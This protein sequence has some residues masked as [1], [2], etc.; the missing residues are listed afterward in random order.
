MTVLVDSA[1]VFYQA[2]WETDI[3]LEGLWLFTDMLGLSSYALRSCYT[4]YTSL[5]ELWLHYQLQ[6]GSFPK[7]ASEIHDNLINYQSELN[8]QG[9]T[10]FIG[11]YT[12]R[13]QDF[14]FGLSRALYLTI[15]QTH[16]KSYVP[17]SLKHM[18]SEPLRA[19]KL[20]QADTMRL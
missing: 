7:A 13:Y 10:S 14:T 1:S 18:L 11:L 5:D 6:I 3:I 20:R 15:L 2:G 19:E 16:F 4:S 12:G 17:G 8:T 9:L